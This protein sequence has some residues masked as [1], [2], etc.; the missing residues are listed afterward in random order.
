VERCLRAV[1]KE[2]LNE[3]KVS[4]L[5]KSTDETILGSSTEITSAGSGCLLDSVKRVDLL[6]ISLLFSGDRAVQIVLLCTQHP[7]HELLDRVARSLRAH[8]EVIFLISS[9]FIY[10]IYS[11]VICYGLT[12]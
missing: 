3:L 2:L 1:S 11:K 6:A 8:L 9:T 5:V 10:I 7:T 12:G 4:S